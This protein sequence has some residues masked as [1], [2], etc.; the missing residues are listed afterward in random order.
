MGTGDGAVS[1]T[2]EDVTVVCGCCVGAPN[3]IAMDASA[4]VAL[5][6]V[7]P[8]AAA[9]PVKITRT[10]ATPVRGYSVTF[11]LSTE[12]ALCA[13]ANSSIL[14]STMLAGFGTGTQFTVTDHLDGTFTV[15]GAIVD[16]PCGSTAALDTLFTVDVSRLVTSGTGTVT[17]LAVELR[18]C[19]DQPLP[20]AVG[21]AATFVIDAIAPLPVTDL[22]AA[23]ALAGS[24]PGRT[25]VMNIGWT[26]STSPDAAAVAVYRK[27]F[28][29]YPEYDDGG[30]TVP[31][32]DPAAT[33]ADAEAAGWTLVDVTADALTADLQATRDVWSYT[34]FCLD[35]YG[36]PSPPAALTTGLPNYIL[37]DV[38]DGLVVEGE[39]LPGDG[40][41]QLDT[42][43]MSL[44]GTYY[45]QT[46]G[47]DHVANRLDIGPLV[48]DP[49]LGRPA[50]DNEIEFEDLILFGI[51]YGQSG[52][53]LKQVALKFAT[54][55]PADR[56]D[57]A[58]VVGTL[59]AVGDVFPVRLEM[60]GDGTIQALSV[61]LSWDAAVVEPVAVQ[62][63]ELLAA[64]GGT[65]LALSPVPGTV[66]IGLMGVRERGIAGRGVVATVSFRVLASG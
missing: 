26:G 38:S 2:L 53:L 45:G 56:N 3:V 57:L 46:I 35:Q 47:L 48:G 1:P 52:L 66:D 27:G 4:V 18:D 12:L 43:D 10:D 34:A 60:S 65:G 7:E 51:N 21:G 29:F 16:T 44:L 54:P 40:D 15:D 11:G 17:I 20:V 41:N 42:I 32:L 63:G 31:A 9:V 28:G 37:G 55:E 23:Q 58:V 22:V 19:A 39:T 30:G 14:E 13:D 49:V 50:T 36:N 25:L 61:P 64:Q 59:P 8:C 5:T 24:G 6:S 33:P 62:G